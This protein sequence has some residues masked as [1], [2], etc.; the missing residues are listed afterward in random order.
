M[1]L[2]RWL[3]KKINFKNNYIDDI[4]KTIKLYNLEKQL[5]REKTNEFKS[6]IKKL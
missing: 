4:E 5:K 2:L 6:K 1:K 3:M